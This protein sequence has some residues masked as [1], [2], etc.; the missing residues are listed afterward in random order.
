MIKKFK[1]LKD[2]PAHKAGLI[3][4]VGLGDGTV[5]TNVLYPMDSCNR[6]C[7][8][9]D[10]TDEWFAPL[11]FIDE[12]GIDVFRGDNFWIVTDGK[13]DSHR[14]SYKT[15]CSYTFVANGQPSS[16]N[17]E[18]FFS[19][20]ESAQSYI[21]SINKP[22]WKTEDGYNV[23][24]DEKVKW[25]IYSI[26]DNQWKYHYDLSMCVPGCATTN[27]ETFRVFKNEDKM[28]AWIEEQNKPKYEVGEWLYFDNSDFYG[29]FRYK[30]CNECDTFASDE[31]YWF[32]KRDMAYYR[33]DICYTTGSFGKD[34]N[35]TKATTSQIESI[36]TKVAIHKGFKEGVKYNGGSILHWD[37]LEYYPREDQFT[38]GHGGSIYC[39]GKWAEIVNTVPEYV[40]CVNDDEFSYIELGVIYKTTPT[41]NDDCVYRIEW[42]DKSGQIIY[43]KWKNY[44]KPSTKEAFDLQNSTKEITI[45]LDGDVV[46]T[47]H[48]GNNVKIVYK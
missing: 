21:D 25:V 36:L 42:P 9:K 26:V 16:W 44:F 22:I 45:T 24:E 43:N 39:K 40:E 7:E 32:P 31:S 30:S 28:N 6:V 1:L 33:T 47:S 37:Y 29:I 19:T 48:W 41:S 8:V 4:K 13:L 10:I 5:N 46:D 20:R 14:E 35:I 11:D 38:D 27:P 17:G 15:G 12:N 3:C 2:T 23:F 18:K 34:W